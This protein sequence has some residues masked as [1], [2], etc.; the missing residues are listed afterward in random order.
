[1]S[2]PRN[3]PKDWSYRSVVRLAVPPNASTVERVWP[4]E[5]LIGYV[6]PWEY[7]K[8]NGALSTT[9]PFRTFMNDAFD[10]S[11]ALNVEN[12][13]Y[14][15]GVSMIRMEI[16]PPLPYSHR[17]IEIERKDPCSAKR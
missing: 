10:G 16:Y 13:K 4:I 12:S 11:D 8:G 7:G 6:P 15:V 9:N 5:I 3:R 2:R 1:M 17:R 14:V